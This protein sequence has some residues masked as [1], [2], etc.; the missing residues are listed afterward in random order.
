MPDHSP[1]MATRD[2][3][4]RYRGRRHETSKRYSERSI[5]VNLFEAAVRYSNLPGIERLESR[6]L[7][8]DTS[9]IETS[10]PAIRNYRC[11]LHA[12]LIGGLYHLPKGPVFGRWA[13]IRCVHTDK[14]LLYGNQEASV[15]QLV[16]FS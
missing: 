13:S 2:T 15:I 4:F 9:T 16:G 8:S 3:L 7:D 6:L 10:I 14:D 1:S 11:R 12:T 5:P